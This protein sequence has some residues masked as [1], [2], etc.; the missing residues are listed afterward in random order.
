MEL[1]DRQLAYLDEMVKRYDLPDR[2]KALR[3]LVKF[4]MHDTKHEESIYT[5]I[6]CLDC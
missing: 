5:E 3:V 4:A 1:K 2:S 6:R